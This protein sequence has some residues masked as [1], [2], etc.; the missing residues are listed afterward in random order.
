MFIKAAW[1]SFAGSKTSL[2]SSKGAVAP[3]WTIEADTMK[4]WSKAKKMTTSAKKKNI[5]SWVNDSDQ[6]KEIPEDPKSKIGIAESKNA[7]SDQALTILPI[8]P[9]TFLVISLFG[10]RIIRSQ[11]GWGPKVAKEN[12][13]WMGSGDTPMISMFN[14][15]SEEAFLGRIVATGDGCILPSLFPVP[16]RAK[17]ETDLAGIEYLAFSVAEIPPTPKA[18]TW[19]CF[20]TNS[21]ESWTNKR[22]KLRVE[23]DFILSV[24]KW[25]FR[26]IVVSSWWMIL[27]WPTPMFDL[28]F[29]VPRRT[30]CNEKNQVSRNFHF[31]DFSR[32]SRK[33]DLL[34][35][36]NRPA[37]YVPLFAV[38][39]TC[40]RFWSC[41]SS[42]SIILSRRLMINQFNEKKHRFRIFGRNCIATASPTSKGLVLRLLSSNLE[43]F[44]ELICSKRYNAVAESWKPSI[45]ND[46]ICRLRNP[47]WL[48]LDRWRFGIYN[49]VNAIGSDCWEFS[50]GKAHE[51]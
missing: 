36:M 31:G 2:N 45:A 32:S 10:S 17:A 18:D 8:F 29:S 21:K 46:E 15:T 44:F 30:F 20:K 3:G 28:S 22:A 42:T 12:A 49:G 41:C 13:V 11:K 50:L 34:N 5:E 40:N 33:F 47:G 27:E 14:W 51:W 26:L 9:I 43:K 39:Y 16:V 48:V 24:V 6:F 4:K 23:I 37:R 19:S 35:P 1:L 7:R 38:A 25:W